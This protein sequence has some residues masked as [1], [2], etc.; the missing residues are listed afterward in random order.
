MKS[1]FSRACG[2]LIYRT[3]DMQSQHDKPVPVILVHKF[4]LVN[5]HF[6]KY[7]SHVR[8]HRTIVK[9][10]LRQSFEDKSI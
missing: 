4:L 7:I 10:A 5:L 8:N 9:I 6:M 2:L 3:G 1:F